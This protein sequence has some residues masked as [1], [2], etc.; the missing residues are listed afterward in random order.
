MLKTV[1]DL[2]RGKMDSYAVNFKLKISLCLSTVAVIL[3]R[4]ECFGHASIS[5]YIPG[6][7]THRG[8]CLCHCEPETNTEGTTVSFIFSFFLISDNC[9]VGCICC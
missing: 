6:N 2:N 5:S 3:Y 4:C 8:K 7:A 1:T 9:Y